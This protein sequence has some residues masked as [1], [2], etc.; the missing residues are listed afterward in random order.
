MPGVEP[1]TSLGCAGK[2]S[3]PDQ[4]SNHDS[5]FLA[6]SAGKLDS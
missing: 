3:E 2:Y 1:V 4:L 5:L 6:G